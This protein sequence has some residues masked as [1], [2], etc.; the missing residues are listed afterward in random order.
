[1]FKVDELVEAT[2]GRLVYGRRDKSV[3]GISID[4]RTFRPPDAFIAIKGTNFD[5]HD[6]IPEVIKK[7]A[8]CIISE[9][10]GIKS[11]PRHAA[12][13]TRRITFIEVKDTT[14]ALGDIARFRRSQFDIP[15]IAIT[16]S[17]GKTTT[18]EMIAQTLSGSLNVLKNEG[19][20]NNHI[21]VP[22]TLLGLTARHEAVVLELGTNHFGEIAYLTRICQPTIGVIT[23]IGPSHLE[24]FK[25]LEGVFREKFSLIKNLKNP[26]I[27][28]LNADC[29]SFSKEL[30][31]VTKNRCQLDFGIKN[32][33]DFFASSLKAVLGGWQFLVNKKYKLT[34]RTLGYYN[35]YNA[36]AAVAVGRLLGVQHKD[37]ARALERFDFPAGRLKCIAL[38]NVTFIDDTY[39]SNPLSLEQA[40][41]A[42]ARCKVKGRKIFVMG[43]MLELGDKGE[44]LHAKVGPQV[45]RICDAL[46]TVGRLSKTS[47]ERARTCGLDYRNIFTCGTSQEA[48]EVLYKRIAPQK[49][50]IVLVKGSRCMKMEEVLNPLRRN[51]LRL[52]PRG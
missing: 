2:A 22:L 32:N 38:D 1:M 51:P 10:K 39:N 29:L 9:K 31:R 6:F 18:K 50:D 35:I 15:V 33:A 17:S 24:F 27:A 7:G 41:N 45:A 34:L 12:R 49:N 14:K 36:L 20:K 43:D 5:G 4:S 21:G 16:G 47:A 52:K 40:L 26:G 37:L 23:N 42:L 28:V 3:R 25:S 44:K 30:A 8:T 11:C 19:T 48:R 13:D 46:I